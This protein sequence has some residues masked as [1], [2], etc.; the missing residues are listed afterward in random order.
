MAIITGDLGAILASVYLPRDALASAGENQAAFES[1]LADLAQALGE[2]ATSA[3]SA[4]AG[5]QS[6]DE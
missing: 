2:D 3:Q 1:L 4:V 6:N 5:S